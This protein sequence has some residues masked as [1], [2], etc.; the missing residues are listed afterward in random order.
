MTDFLTYEA[1]R[2][3]L[4]ASLAITAGVG[5]VFGLFLPFTDETD[6]DEL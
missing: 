2:T 6:G 3:Y 5:I 1:I 4:I